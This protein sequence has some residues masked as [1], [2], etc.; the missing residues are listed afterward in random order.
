MPPPPPPPPAVG[1]S[2]AT[3]VVEEAVGWTG[4]LS[5][6]SDTDHAQCVVVELVSHNSDDTTGCP[7]AATDAQCCQFMMDGS[8]HYFTMPVGA[9]HFLGGVPIGSNDRCIQEPKD[10]GCVIS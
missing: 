3:G 10:S 1:D 6:G 9:C 7:P 2:P 8:N 4:N 5:L